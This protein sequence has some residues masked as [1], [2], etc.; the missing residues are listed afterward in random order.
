LIGAAAGTWLLWRR[1]LV[2]GTSSAPP[3]FEHLAKCGC[4]DGYHGPDTDAGNCNS[5]A[6]RCPEVFMASGEIL[7]WKGIIVADLGQPSEERSHSER[8]ASTQQQQ[9]QLHHRLGTVAHSW[10]TAVA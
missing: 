3:R 5:G 7:A 1:P 8:E 4:K 6:D 9:T 2:N 10:P